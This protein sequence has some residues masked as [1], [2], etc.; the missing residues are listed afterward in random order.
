VLDLY[1]SRRLVAQTSVFAAVEN[2]LDREYD[3]GR[4]PTLTIGVP[5]AF[6]GGIRIALP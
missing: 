4:T 6:R 2:A 1:V 3:V 5:R